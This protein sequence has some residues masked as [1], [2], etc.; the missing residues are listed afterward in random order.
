MSDG[1]CVWQTGNCEEKQETWAE[2]ANQWADIPAVQV[3]SSG[4][5]S[6]RGTVSSELYIE[7][8]SISVQRKTWY[9]TVCQHPSLKYSEV[10]N[11]E[12][13]GNTEKYGEVQLSTVKCS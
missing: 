10:K 1:V 11:I 4:Q 12:E 2:G 6:H 3:D 9:N 8:H 5:R 7:L 13:Q